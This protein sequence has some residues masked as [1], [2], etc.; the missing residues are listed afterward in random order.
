MTVLLR[1]SQ[2]GVVALSLKLCMLLAYVRTCVRGCA[3][4]SAIYASGL[5]VTRS[6]FGACMSDYI[7]T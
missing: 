1:S 4:V 3:V 2:I 5:C 7:H 6:A